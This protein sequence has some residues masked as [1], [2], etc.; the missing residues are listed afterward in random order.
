MDWFE[1]T[2]IF[3]FLIPTVVFICV[4]LSYL[5]FK[6]L[7]N[8]ITFM[9]IWWGGWLFIA[10]LSLTGIYI[11]GV[12]TQSLIILMLLAYTLGALI[13]V[14]TN[15]KYKKNILFDKS[16]SININFH[17]QF[18]SILNVSYPILLIFVL[19]FF[20]KAI[21]LLRTSSAL[22]LQSYRSK[23]FSTSD[24]ASILYG[25]SQVELFY[26]IFLYSLILLCLIISSI[27]L[28]V[29]G[30]RLYILLS[31]FLNFCKS[32]MT[33]GR[34]ELYFIF[35]FLVILGFLF[36]KKISDQLN[37]TLALLRI[38]SRAGKRLLFY[39]LFILAIILLS[40]TIIS[41]VRISSKGSK[42]SYYE[43]FYDFI[44]WY[45]TCGFVLLDKQLEDPY[46]I[47]SQNM[48]YGLST[49]SSLERILFLI[50]TRFDKDFSGIFPLIGGKE[51]LVLYLHEF[52]ND[53]QKI[54]SAPDRYANAFYTMVYDFYIDGREIGVFIF[55]FILGYITSLFYQDWIKNNNLYS[56]SWL[57][58]FLYI[59]LMSI[60]QSQFSSIPT[61]GFM[62]LLL[63]IQNYKYV[64]SKKI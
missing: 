3:I 29:Y 14:K 23:I 34:F 24:K 53:F 36:N 59:S 16:I 11:P 37:S 56:L 54:G 33:L 15:N 7:A 51:Q 58:L 60:F 47:L 32:V 42:A 50:I 63:L 45:H 31:T 18:K 52:M 12:H 9:T 6:R 64:F 4:F 40:V 21:Y 20:V 13:V 19:P 39:L 46:S 5:K 55:S 8:P 22:E 27:F 25:S 61:W 41:V 26:V 35:F 10:N 30:N 17:K 43:V 48:T 1:D 44:I 28:Y 38:K 49:F 57:L 2:A 62:L